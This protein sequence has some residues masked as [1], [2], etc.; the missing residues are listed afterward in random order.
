MPRI[1]ST[2]FEAA[3]ADP[4]GTL[5]AVDHPG[6]I[7]A[8]ASLI[9]TSEPGTAELG[10]IVEDCWQGRGIGRLLVTCLVADALPRGITTV[11]AAVL[12]D[13]AALA[14]K[15]RRIPGHYTLSLDGPTCEARVRLAR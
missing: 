10:V 4:D 8:I 11:I 12:S 7:V 6:H 14:A 13:H 15:L 1:P 5:I 3:L 2:Y 9:Q